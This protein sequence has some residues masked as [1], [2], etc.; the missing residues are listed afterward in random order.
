MIYLRHKLF[1][2]IVLLSIPCTALSKRRSRMRKSQRLE[3]RRKVVITDDQK[4]STALGKQIKFMK[5]DDAVLAM[6]Y[7]IKENNID[8]AIKCGQRAIAVGGSQEVMRQIRFKLAELFLEKQKLK[9]AED[10]A[11]EY[12]KFYPGTIE[13]I[14]AEY[15]I[16]RAQ[17]SQSIP[18]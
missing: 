12:Q 10:T 2:F 5:F 1:F 6:N 13:A 14:K 17:L 11:R 7:Y 9:D 8:V 18:I 4:L 3:M 16:I 15:I